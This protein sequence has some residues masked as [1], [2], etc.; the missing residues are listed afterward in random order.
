MYLLKNKFLNINNSDYFE[1]SLTVAKL[2]YSFATT[3]QRCGQKADSEPFVY[4]ISKW[5]M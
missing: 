4:S 3:V 1:A 2:W 5:Q